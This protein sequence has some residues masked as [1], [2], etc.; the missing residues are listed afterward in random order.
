MGESFVSTVSRLLQAW[1]AHRERGRAGIGT[2]FAG[3]EAGPA[4]KAVKSAAMWW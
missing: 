4:E 2:V 1:G 3:L